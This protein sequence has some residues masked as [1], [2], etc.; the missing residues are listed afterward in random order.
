MVSTA[1]QALRP[2]FL[3][4]ILAASDL[5]IYHRSLGNNRSL[6]AGLFR[7]LRLIT[8]LI[9]AR[10][11]II[12]ARRGIISLASLDNKLIQLILYQKPK[13]A[14]TDYIT[15]TKIWL[16]FFKKAAFAQQKPLKLEPISKI[17]FKA[18][19]MIIFEMGSKLIDC[20]PRAIP[21]RTMAR[22][23]Y[24]L[25]G[26]AI[27]C[28]YPLIRKSKKILHL[29]FSLNFISVKEESRP[30][31][32]LRADH[33]SFDGNADHFRT[34]GKNS[35]PGRPAEFLWPQTCWRLFEYR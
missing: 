11:E 22:D 27:E 18:F 19:R 35:A 2:S 12:P 33:R 4:G 30:A 26:R 31:N 1:G 23:I 20:R 17:T 16:I 28:L 9:I 15:N 13:I 14:H 7:S 6:G 21:G 25:Y 34:D 32:Q 5:G 29:K 8:N 3:K 24:T 10:S